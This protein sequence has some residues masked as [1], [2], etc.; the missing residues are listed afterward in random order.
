MAEASPLNGYG[1]LD[2]DSVVRAAA[3]L[4]ADETS[5]ENT[6][7]LEGGS[8]LD[9]GYAVVANFPTTPTG[10]SP[11]V[12][13]NLKA[14]DAGE[15][16]EVT[17]TDAIDSNTTYPFTLVLPVPPSRSENWEVEFDV[18]GTSPVFANVSAYVTRRVHAKVDA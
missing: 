14:S 13:V 6:F 7:T 9:Q 18:S 4:N 11:S 5:S 1:P 16:I 3:T 12:K 10:T 2:S 8:P 17:H 15:L